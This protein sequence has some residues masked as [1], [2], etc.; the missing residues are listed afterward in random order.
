MRHVDIAFKRR[1]FLV[2]LTTFSVMCLWAV[3]P[4]CLCVRLDNIFGVYTA[5]IRRSPITSRTIHWCLFSY[6]MFINRSWWWRIQALNTNDSKFI[7]LV[8]IV[9]TV[10][11]IFLQYL[12]NTFR[13]CC[14]SLALSAKSIFDQSCGW[15]RPRLV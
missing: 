11:S 9:L 2:V 13:T 6:I 1:P 15:Q 8:F 14:K 4:P 7:T 12:C 10:P 5:F 3:T